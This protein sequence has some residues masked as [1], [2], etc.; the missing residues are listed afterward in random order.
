MAAFAVFNKSEIVVWNVGR[1]CLC[2]SVDGSSPVYSSR[3]MS[4]SSFHISPHTPVS[5][6]DARSD[7]LRAVHARTA[8]RGPGL[9]P[10][11]SSPNQASPADSNSSP[12]SSQVSVTSTGSSSSKGSDSKETVGTTRII[13]QQ[14][15]RLHQAADFLK[16]LRQSYENLRNFVYSVHRF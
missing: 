13:S 3:V 16:V 1:D 2:C 5:G 11:D 15:S 10:R 9:S 14:V 8:Q 7:L 4:S 6:G 12:R